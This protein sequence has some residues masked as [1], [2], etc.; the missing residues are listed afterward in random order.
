MKSQGNLNKCLLQVIPSVFVEQGPELMKGESMGAL[1]TECLSVN[2]NGA[3]LNPTK[4]A[5]AE[6]DSIT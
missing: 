4:L 5:P 2:K 1:P 3:F 6:G